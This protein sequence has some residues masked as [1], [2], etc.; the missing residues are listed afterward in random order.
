MLLCKQHSRQ[1]MQK[2]EISSSSSWCVYGVYY[3]EIIGLL[4]RGINLVMFVNVC[5]CNLYLIVQCPR[6]APTNKGYFI[7]TTLILLL[8][9]L[10]SLIMF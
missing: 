5:T 8:L 9:L 7:R 4:L 6:M 2:L 1:G 3:L 10:Y